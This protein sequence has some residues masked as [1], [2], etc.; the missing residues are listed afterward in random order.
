MSINVSGKSL[1]SPYLAPSR[2]SQIQNN[3]GAQFRLFR[4]LDVDDDGVLAPREFL[5]GCLASD[6]VALMDWLASAL[7]DR[8]LAQAGGAWARLGASTPIP[9]LMRGTPTHCFPSWCGWVCAGAT[10]GLHRFV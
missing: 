7:A 4:A 8:A 10:G 2:C 3:L 1:L 5:D 9:S 6:D